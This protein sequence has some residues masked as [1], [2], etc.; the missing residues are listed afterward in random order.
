MNNSRRRL[1]AV[2][3]V[4][5]VALVGFTAVRDG[6]SPFVHRCGRQLCISDEPFLIH[7]ATAYGTYDRPA[8]EI[9]LALKAHLNTLAVVEFETKHHV[10]SDA[11]STATW[12]R[13]DKFIATARA[14]GIHIILTL[15][16]YAQSLQKAGRTPTRTDWYTYL[17]FIANRINTVTK[18]PYR[19]EPT[20]AMVQIWGEACFPGETDSTCPAGTSGTAA[21]MISFYHRTLTEWK[22]LAPHVLITTG[23]FSHLNTPKS[24]GIPWQAIMSD[25]A[26]PLCELEVNSRGDLNGSVSKVTNFCQHLG[27]PWYLA[28]WSSCY[29]DPGYPI[30]T[31]TD[32][33][34]ARHAQDMYDVGQGGAPAAMPAVGTAFWNLKDA[35]V[36]PGLCDISPAFPRTFSV[37]QSNA[38]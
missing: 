23:G 18:V 28:A 17:K 5:V 25:P 4:G 24:S 30:Y 10:L 38:P 29:A 9:E 1:V 36:T 20:I 8:S 19:D 21:E 6:G 2:L 7:G 33:E 12:T 22:L 26:D 3:I 32:T 16:S 15:S 34:M 27:K 35:G 13:V 37:I 31:S 14:A 11:M